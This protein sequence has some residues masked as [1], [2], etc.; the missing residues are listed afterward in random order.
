VHDIPAVIAEI[1]G[2]ACVCGP[3]NWII[4]EP[5]PLNYGFLVR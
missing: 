5:D 1:Y 4:D 2:N 3:A